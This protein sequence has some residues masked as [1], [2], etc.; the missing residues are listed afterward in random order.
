MTSTEESVMTRVMKL[1]ALANDESATPAERQLAAERAEKIM[2]DNMIDRF[3]AAQRLKNGDTNARKPIHEKWVLPIADTGSY[4]F[5]GVVSELFQYVLQHCNIRLS[6]KV[7]HTN[8]GGWEFDVVGFREDIMYAERIWFN[9]FKAF[10][11]NVNP[12]WSKENSIEYNAYMFASAG[13]SWKDQVLLAEKSG[14]DRIDWPWRYQNQNPADRNTYTEFG[15]KVGKP[16]DPGNAPWGRAIHKLKRACKKY[17]TDN[18]VEYPYASGKNLRTATRTSFARSY[19]STITAR[20]SELR[21]KAKVDN[22]SDNN[23]FALAL[24]D[25]RARV[26]EEF[27]R[28]F[29]EYDPENIRKRYEEEDFLRACEWAELTPEEQRRVLK[30]QAEQRAREERRAS[31]AQRNYRAM[32]EDPANRIDSAAWARG[33]DIASKVNLRADE[34][35]S[36]Q[37]RQAVRSQPKGIE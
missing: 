13:M 21:R 16:I 27:Y 30:E 7:K 29:P 18:G 31:R 9:V 19:R 17:C 36:K 33:R 5:N 26:D 32:R 15:W 2:A 14:D 10:V 28:I 4:E 8:D 1:M 3:E 37:E 35:V 6:H 25:T 20:L 22:V 12:K 11:N 23:K 24:N 34:E